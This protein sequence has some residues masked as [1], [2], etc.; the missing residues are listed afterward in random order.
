MVNLVL[1][2]GSNRILRTFLVQDENQHVVLM[3]N[4]SRR[5]ELVKSTEQ[6]EKDGVDF[7]VIEKLTVKSLRAKDFSIS[8]NLS[9]GVAH[10]EL[11]PVLASD[12]A[13]EEDQKTLTLAY[14]YS[15]G[16][17]AAVIALI[18]LTGWIMQ[19]F[20][21]KPEDKPLEIV[22]LPKMEEKLVEVKKEKQV[23]KVAETKQQLKP[24]VKPRTQTKILPKPKVRTAQITQGMKQSKNAEI[25]TLR[26]LE[27]IGGIGTSTDAKN[28]GTGYG[29]NS[30]AFGS[31]NSFGGGL[32][33]GV[34]GGMKDG[35]S[36]KGLVG[37]L[38][39]NGSRSFG[40]HGYGEGKF[41]GG[42]VGRGGGSLG[43]KVGD[44]MVPAFEDSEIVGGL[45]REQVEAVVRR[46]SGQLLFC[47][48]K[49]LQSQPHLRGR[50]TSQ[51]EIGPAGT[52]TK[53]KVASSSLNNR[54]VENCVI[55]SIKGWKF[56]RPVGGVHVD[57]SYPFDFG[58][59]NLMAKEN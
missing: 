53:A 6:Y 36:G 55:A 10:S 41:G 20:F 22:V 16:A 43:R 40:A 49:A 44:I 50:V 35:L 28:K 3:N 19:T 31:G 26:T 46:N 45:T 11:K 32:G 14:K 18:L 27:K 12:M 39:G 9:L 56:P 7:S 38:S 5:I 58:R 1:K 30:G 59:L 51:W 15:T 37:G 57:V 48:E 23:V 33:S 21:M 24:Q 52:V 17:H 2:D 13:Q 29:K 42:R 8:S 25:G 34:G 47:Y 4:D 54:Q